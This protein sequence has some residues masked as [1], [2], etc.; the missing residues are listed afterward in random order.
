MPF[1]FLSFPFFPLSRNRGLSGEKRPESAWRA[2][3]G[4]YPPLSVSNHKNTHEPKV[5]VHTTLPPQLPVPFFPLTPP[6]LNPTDAVPEKPCIKD[7][8][9]DL[10][11]QHLVRY[12]ARLGRPVRPLFVFTVARNY[13]PE[14][15]SVPRIW[16]CEICSI[17]TRTTTDI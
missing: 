10:P 6:P 11:T 9:P 15:S 5:L 7:R 16:L 3:S 13:V 2:V 8:F 12:D 1:S 4:L 14:R 17:A